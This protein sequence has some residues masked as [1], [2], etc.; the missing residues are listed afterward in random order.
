[1]SYKQKLL[2]YNKKIQLAGSSEFV[3]NL[4][5]WYEIPN[6]GHQ[7]CGIFLSEKYPKYL[8]KCEPIEMGDYHEIT[9]IVNHI[10][11]QIQLFPIIINSTRIDTKNYLTMQKLDGDITSFYYNL[12]SNIALD[13]MS[14]SKE[15]KHDILLLFRG[16]MYYTLKNFNSKDNFNLVHLDNF[17]MQ[18]V[19]DDDF[20]E[21]YKKYKED[22]PEIINT[23]SSVKIK[24]K[25]YSLFHNQDNFLIESVKDKIR[26]I[27]T[28]SNITFELYDSFIT[29]LLELWTMYHPIISREI[30]KIK[31]LLAN[32]GYSYE[33]SKYD[34]LGY[35][36]NDNPDNDAPLIFDKYLHVYFIDSTSGLNNTY[37][38]NRICNNIILTINSGVDYTVNG[39]GYLSEIN[40][41]VLPYNPINLD[42]L[43]LDPEI[44]K[45]IEKEYRFDTTPYRHIYNFT[46]ITDLEIHIFG[47][48]KLSL[49]EKINTEFRERFETKRKALSEN[50]EFINSG[51]DIA[52]FTTEQLIDSEILRL[53]NKRRLE[54]ARRI[55]EARYGSK[56]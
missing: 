51:Q 37:D 32:L 19:I 25:E 5:E 8:C 45:I 33:D 15:Q 24:E 55:I 43:G 13:T 16:K 29:K 47:S 2:K 53:E 46:N 7:N 1:M 50:S 18:C 56:N 17:S 30:I 14:I 41:S 39:D 44:I 6:E 40:L 23:W 26:K 31:L 27:K 38:L 21:E 4:D 54:E 20:Y 52:K 9:D 11:S 3:L 12:L 42:P 22:H 35:I 34:N 28:I 49:Q 10:N 36:L 48:P